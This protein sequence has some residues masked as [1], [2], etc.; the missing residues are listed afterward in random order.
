MKFKGSGT[1]GPRDS[2]MKFDSLDKD[3]D[4]DDDKG[5]QKQPDEV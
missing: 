3:K 1:T 4:E 5:P 2:L